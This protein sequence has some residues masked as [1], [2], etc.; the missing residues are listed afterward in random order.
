MIK[1]LN[2]MA[3]G[4]VILALAGGC[5]S[6]TD[7]PASA[8]SVAL[9]TPERIRQARAIDP[10][11]LSV[12]LRVNGQSY[13]ANR[14]ADGSYVAAVTV[15]ANSNSNV[16]VV[17]T[18]LFEGTRLKLAEQTVSVAVDNTDMTINLGDDYVTTG[19]GFDTDA[20]GFSNLAER[21]EGTNPLSASE[22][23]DSAALQLSVALPDEA[24]DLAA[25]VNLTATVNGEAVVLQRV[26]PGVATATV[27]NL[28]AD[29]RV[30]VAV[31][32]TSN[33]LTLGTAEQSATLQRGDGNTVTIVQSDFN[34][35]FDADN[36]GLS[37]LRE[38]LRG[39]NPNGVI[40][41]VVSSVRNVPQIDGSL[42]EGVWR[43]RLSQNNRLTL[44]QLIVADEGEDQAPTDGLF[45][46]WTAVTDG[47]TLYI[48]VRMIDQSIQL[49]SGFEWWKD[50]GIEL[51]IDGDNSK[52]TGGYDGDNDYH[53]NFRVA[54]GLLIR[55]GRSAGVPDNL[56]YE[57]SSDGF[58]F[59]IASGAFVEDIDQN[60]ATDAGFNLE[61]AI[62]LDELGIDEGEPFGIN[63]HYNDDD[64]G[65]ERDAK[66]TWTGDKGI[67]IDFLEPSSFATALIED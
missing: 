56:V 9:S 28:A 58:D 39:T 15:P 33:G 21:V 60:G 27:D 20:D 4:A 37:N 43:N 17:W 36:D 14:Q 49:D 10:Q 13:A 66:Y 12:E 16:S 22:R 25:E 48:G 23:P 65:G 1:K 24:I 7:T 52:Q 42:D 51:F 35:S 34:T 53:L 61:I 63:L 44:N 26:T 47:D 5:M 19:S 18:E 11:Q 8:S 59:D 38:L 54:D 67:D 31:Q 50:D 41:F 29:T 57:L 32:M 6:E 2:A 40:D 46:A 45:S 30:T 64:N 62:P 3:A 55:G